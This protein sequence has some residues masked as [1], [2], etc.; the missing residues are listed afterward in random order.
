VSKASLEENL[1]TLVEIVKTL[2]KKC[3]WDRKQ[4]LKSLKNNLIEETYEAIEAIEKNKLENIVE[5][6]GDI[7]FLTIFLSVI[8]E[9]KTGFSF[10]KLVTKTIDKY[11]EKHPHVF[12]NIRFKNSIEVVKFWHS[13]KRDI[14]EGIPCSLPA[15]LAAKVIQERASKLGFDWNSREGP[16]KKID[17][18]IDELKRAKMKRKRFEE[19]GDLLFSCVNLARHLKIDPEGALRSANKKFVKRFRKILKILK[20]ERKGKNLSLEEMDRVWDRIKSKTCRNLSKAEQT[21]S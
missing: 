5:E 17:E 12:K 15:L 9:E 8:L 11:R 6:I 21:K 4:T 16:L 13:K 19:M 18:E 2:R 7:L 3:P 10:K 20:K 14:F 1:I